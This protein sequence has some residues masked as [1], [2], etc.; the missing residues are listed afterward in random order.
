MIS[1]AVHSYKGGTGKTNIC[2]NLAAMVTLS[3]KKVCIL[4]L[5]LEAPN[6]HNIFRNDG[7]KW[8]NDYLEGRSKLEDVLIDATTVL[9]R[10][11]KGELKVALA[12]PSMDAVRKHMASDRSQQ[13]SALKRLMAAKSVL[14]SFDYVFMDTSPGVT[15]SSINAVLSADRI[16]LIVR[17]DSFDIDGTRR[18]LS[19]F[20]GGLQKKTG[21]VV[22]RCMKKEDGEK[23]VKSLD[24]PL[25]A[26]IPCYCE[27]P[28]NISGRI[29][30]LE[31]PEHRFRQDISSI[32]E[33]LTSF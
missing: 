17:P 24:V 25:L 30:V 7:K 11:R 29:F 15:Y 31:N 6:L 21:I 16:M 10:R 4:E 1:I 3:G 23:A 32:L 28:Q 13:L 22:N 14:N 12:N 26:M 5:D 2:I 27:I 18:L 8:L 19:E 33:K 9:G 20:Y